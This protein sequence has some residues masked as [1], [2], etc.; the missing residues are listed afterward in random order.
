MDPYFVLQVSSEADDKEVRRAYLAA[1]KEAT[2]ESQPARFK[3]ISAAY[4]LIKTQDGRYKYEWSRQVVYDGTPIEVVRRCLS[5]HPPK[6]PPNFE[7]MKE[8]LRACLK[9]LT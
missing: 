9:Q 8:H 5:F 1:V 4:N 3:E 6:N 2:P 7:Y